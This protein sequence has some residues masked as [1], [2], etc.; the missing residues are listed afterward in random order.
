E[1]RQTNR[2]M[3]REGATKKISL[4]KKR[5]VRTL[6]RANI[7]IFPFDIGTAGMTIEELQVIRMDEPWIYIVLLG[8]VVVV[9][10]LA[11]PRRRASEE[12]ETRAG[13]LEAT[14]EQFM[15][16]METENQQMI[17]TV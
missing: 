8:A 17:E 14:L 5:Q 3:A 12:T 2:D 6:T 10:A 11:L 15:D 9:G 4:L 7:S 16:S 13:N 1:G